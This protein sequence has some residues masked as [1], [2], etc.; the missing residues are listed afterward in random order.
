M[1]VHCKHCNKH[2]SANAT[3]KTE[4]IPLR[5]DGKWS[6]IC[7]HCQHE[8]LTDIPLKPIFV[9][10]SDDSQE[11]QHFNNDFD[12]QCI[13]DA[14]AF[15][16]VTDFMKWWKNAIKEPPSKWYHV[17]YNG[18]QICAGA[19]DPYDLNIFREHFPKIL[20]KKSIS[21]LLLLPYKIK[22]KFTKSDLKYG[23]MV[24]FRNGDKALYM[25]S[26]M[27]DA[28]DYL[29]NRACLS[30]DDYDDKLKYK[31]ENR[32][33]DVLEVRGF[34]SQKYRTTMLDES[35]RPLLYKRKD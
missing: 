20:K 3:L 16:N 5:L 25:P 8:N 28:F 7:T 33:Y 6:T 22:N 9:I 17:I 27:G 2:Y 29:N 18:M 34:S 24:K 13:K 35:E 4:S 10:L 26:K 14:F 32:K 1:Y 19:M 12:G 15:D 11:N 21:A 23:Y 30:V 31:N